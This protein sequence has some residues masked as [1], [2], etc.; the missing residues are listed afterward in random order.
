MFVYA[1]AKAVRIGA[2]DASFY[3][4]A[5]KGYEGILNNLIYKDSRG[6]YNLIYVCQGAGLGG[7][8]SEKIRDGS[9]EYYVYIEA[10][11]A[12]DGKGIGPFMMASVEIEK[13]ET[14]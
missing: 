13:A 12:N 6:N 7:T 14:K 1:I 8:Y 10:R 2:V 3:Q 9:F 4:V 5:K 11:V